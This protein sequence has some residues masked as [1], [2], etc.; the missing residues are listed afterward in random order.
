MT[1]KTEI[2][3]LTPD[4]HPMRH[5]RSYVR[6][7]GRKTIRQEAAI[8]ML[9][10]QVGRKICDGAVRFDELYGRE[11]P[12]WLEIG[13]GM[14]A[15]LVEQATRHPDINFLG[16]EVHT[17]GVGAMLAAMQA[18]AC[19]NIR[20]FDEDAIEV[21]KQ[22]LPDESLDRVQLFFPDPWPKARHHKRRIVQA[23]FAQQIR[24]KLKIGGIFHMATDW[25]NYAEH[26]RDVMNLAPGYKNLS[27]SNDFIPRPDERPFTKFEKR[28]ERLGHGV[29]DL[30]FQ[31]TA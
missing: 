13:F 29:W 30:M 23:A 20:V 17:P 3:E 2:P 8:E 5:I 7:E 22:C 4:G 12:V 24:A 27:A 15:S 11:A 25:E 10:P 18:A 1:I 19:D 26:M 16:I 31:R 28:G 14:G 9:F 6:R 21:L